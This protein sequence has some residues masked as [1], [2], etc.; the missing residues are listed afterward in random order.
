MK[1]FLRAVRREYGLYLIF[2]VP[3]VWY[4]IFMYVPMYGLQIAFKRYNARLGI[5]GSPWVGMQYF[6]QF[7]DSYYFRDLLVNTLVLNVFQMAVGFP[8]PILLALIINEIRIRPLQKAVQNITYIP[9]FLSIVVIVSMLK[10]FSNTEYGLFNKIVTF[11]GGQPVDYFAKVGAFRPLYVFSGVWQNMGFNSVIY[12]AALSAID[13]QLYEAASIDGASRIRKIIHV[14]IP[15]IA[16]TIVILF[17]MR[18]GSLMNVGFEKVLLMQNNVNMEVSDV[19][20]TFIY[21]NG[22]QKGQLSYS[23]AVGIFNSLINLFLLLGANR[24]TRRI[25]DTGL[26]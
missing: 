8:V 17:I 7:F 21:R 12:I 14:S 19:I 13:P 4:V 26:W 10:L 23:A 24:L 16:P 11:F 1:N 20:S 6:K 2:L 9:Y 25:G 15:Q 3:L 22:I 5:L 18:I